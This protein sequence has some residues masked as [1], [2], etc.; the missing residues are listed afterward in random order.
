LPAEARRFGPNNCD[1]APDALAD[2]VSGAKAMA[3]LGFNCSIPHKVAVIEYLDELAR[4]AEIIGA[5]NCVVIRDGRLIGEN[6][7]GKGFLS[8]LQTV[9]QPAG[10]N[11][12]IFG[13]RGCGAG[14]RGGDGV[15]RRQNHHHRQPRSGTW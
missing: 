14:D 7:D 6:T 1:V 11:I 9:V 13:A 5:V 15:G 2:A 4:S 8:S 3:W 10:R 12:L